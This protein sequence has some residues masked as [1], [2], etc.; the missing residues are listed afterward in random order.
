MKKFWNIMKKVLLV[1]SALT[2]ITFFI[3]GLTSAIK[4]QEQLVC[5]SIQVKVDYDAGV[6]FIKEEEI[7]EKINYL[8]AGDII[9]KPLTGIDFRT[10]ENE[11]RKNPYV[12]NAEIF[13]DQ[14]QNV[15]TEI[16]QKQPILRVINTDGVS[17]YISDKSDRI[18]LSNNFTPHVTVALGNIAMNKD[19]QRDSTVIAGLYNL[20][21]YIRQ[22]TFLNALVDQ[23]YVHE[24]GEFDLIPK[25]PGHTIKFGK[26]G[27]NMDDKFNRLKIFYKE[28]L[29]KVGWEQYKTINL[30]FENQVVCEK[31]DTTNNS[32]NN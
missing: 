2:V 22:D 29:S 26:P 24:N 23:V 18:P 10:I 32:I 28:G 11:L 3:I 4:K 5:N 12:D 16:V 1:L 25:I 30:K 8:C 14:Q 6:S 20:A 31:R 27:E 19:A 9:G 13:T 17:F 15:I 7:T 21:T